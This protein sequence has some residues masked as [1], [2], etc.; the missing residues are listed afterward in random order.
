MHC[1]KI[2]V[3]TNNIYLQCAIKLLTESQCKRR[4]IPYIFISY[5]QCAESR[6]TATDFCGKDFG[7]NTLIFSDNLNGGV[8][9]PQF[10]LASVN[11]I[12]GEIDALMSLITLSI[13][14]LHRIDGMG[15]IPEFRLTEPEKRTVRDL[16]NGLSPD[17]ISQ[18]EKM[19]VK[20]VSAY[21]RKAM[22]KLNVKSLQQ[23]YNQ[24]LAS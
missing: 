14:R 19:S 17:D 9:S 24:C 10:R 21:K 1:L 2:V 12:P 8:I 16:L 5:P 20:T 15:D 7:A 13:Y 23:L 3:F 6:L 4:N 22:N 11:K 18:K